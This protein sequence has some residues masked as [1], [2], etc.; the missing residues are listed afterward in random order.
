M[1]E[2]ACIKANGKAVIPCLSPLMEHL[3]T[4]CFGAA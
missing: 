1:D 4:V 3:N 2:A